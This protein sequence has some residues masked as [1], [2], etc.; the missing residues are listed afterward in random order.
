GVERPEAS[1]QRR[2]DDPVGAQ[3]RPGRVDGLSGRVP[4]VEVLAR[5][6]G[7]DLLPGEAVDVGD[8]RAGEELEVVVGGRETGLELAGLAVPGRG[9]VLPTLVLGE[10]EVEGAED[11]RGRRHVGDAGGHLAE[12]AE[13]DGVQRRR[14]VVAR[15]GSHI[16]LKRLRLAVLAVA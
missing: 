14:V 9:R 5:G 11:A 15:A 1:Y 12:G 8:G 13:A 2:R 7:E 4:G 16:A 10:D 6:A 3:L